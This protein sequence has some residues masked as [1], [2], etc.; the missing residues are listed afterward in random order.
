MATLFSESAVHLLLAAVRG[1]GY[2]NLNDWPT[3]ATA[4]LLRAGYIKVIASDVPGR[5]LKLTKEGWRASANL[6]A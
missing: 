3:D 6:D 5:N 1:G 4:D 2:A